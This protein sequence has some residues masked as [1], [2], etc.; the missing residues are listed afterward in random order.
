VGPISGS[1]GD[2]HFIDAGE[3]IRHNYLGNAV[4]DDQ[5]CFLGWPSLGSW[6]H[7]VAE[8]MGHHGQSCWFGAVTIPKVD[9]GGEIDWWT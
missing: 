4:P 9:S 6:L 3:G 2:D 5:A 1:D 7:E 8:A